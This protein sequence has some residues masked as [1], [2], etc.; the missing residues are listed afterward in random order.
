[1]NKAF[2]FD[3]DGVIVNSERIWTR[4][5][6]KF[7]PQLMGWQTYRK[8][9]NEILGNSISNIYDIAQSMGF[10]MHKNEFL[11][12]YCQYA[13]IVYQEAKLTAGIEELITKLVSLKFK[14]CLV[15]VSRQDWI[16]IV[17]SK[18]K[19]NSFD[20]VLSLD[21]QGLKSKPDPEGYIKTI[22]ALGMNP[23]NTIILEDSE[24]GIKAAKKSGAF[25]ICLKENL[26]KNYLPKGADLYINTIKELIE[27]LEEMEL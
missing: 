14:I 3:M 5:E 25:T 10:K 9:K 21:S 18:F 12:I 20:Y 22:Q 7:M 15:S 2:I 6:K 26:A 23:N 11:K 1:M 4:Y 13:D 16:D 17:I 8:I 19:K 27:K 24:K